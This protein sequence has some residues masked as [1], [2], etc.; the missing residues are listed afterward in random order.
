MRKKSKS[1]FGTSVLGSGCLGAGLSYFIVLSPTFMFFGFVIGII[2]GVPL[3]LVSFAFIGD[4]VTSDQIFYQYATSFAAGLLTIC[5]GYLFNYGL[6]FFC[7]EISIIVFIICT[8]LIYKGVF[9][10]NLSG[11]KDLFIGNKSRMNDDWD[12]YDYYS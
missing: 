9:Y 1:N 3:S 5:I 2:I 12:K 11:I 10:G 8:I 7:F 4:K 6:I